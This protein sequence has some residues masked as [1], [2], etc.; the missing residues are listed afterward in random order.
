MLAGSGVLFGYHYW[1]GPV[2]TAGIAVWFAAVF[3][4]ALDQADKWVD[5]FLYTAFHEMGH[6][7]VAAALDMKIRRFYVGPFDWRMRDG[8]WQFR[9]SPA[10][11]LGGM[12]GAVGC[13]P[14]SM[15]EFRWRQIGVCAAG[16]LASLL[17]GVVAFG[18][19]LEAKGMPWEHY[20]RLFSY[21]ST[22]GILGFLVNLIPLR[23]ESN[24]SDGAN[25]YQLLAA[26]PA[27]KV[28]HAF[29]MV[30]STMVSP[31]HPRDYDLDLIQE[32]AGACCGQRA[33]L[34][35]LSAVSGFLDRG[36][37]AEANEALSHAEAVYADSAAA[38]P[39]DQRIEIH[40]AFTFGAAVIRRDAAAAREWWERTTE[41][42]PEGF[43]AEAWRG[44]CAFLWIEGRVTEARH[45][46]AQGNAIV[47]Q[48]PK[49]GGY[50]FDRDC[51]AMLRNELEAVAA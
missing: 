30:S 4:L 19:A 15:E 24:Y 21:L 23:P 34:L 44:Y 27:S 50:E 39:V 35:Q 38:M 26:G 36:Q 51:F 1:F 2:V 18:M 14:A 5:A 37:I 40:D 45:A 49:G 22:F 11:L 33:L 7:V 17:L 42:R 32:A 12:P 13:V 31:L 3:S 20:W 29:A 48:Y 6:A 25:I 10:A 16:P 41:K 28:Q 9:F 47:Q 46:W 43:T 8:K